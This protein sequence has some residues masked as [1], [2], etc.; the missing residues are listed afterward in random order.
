MRVWM[1]KFVQHTA[2]LISFS[3]P[4]YLV[5]NLSYIRRLLYEVESQTLVA[6][7]T[8]FPPPGSIFLN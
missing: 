4:I 7:A 3:A 8:I 5:I 6:S 2:S 1:F